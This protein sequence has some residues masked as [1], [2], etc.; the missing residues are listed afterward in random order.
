MNEFPTSGE[1]HEERPA[2]CA[3][4]SA[5]AS[6]ADGCQQPLGDDGREPAG[7]YPV[8]GRTPEYNRRVA[9]HEIGHV[10]L[11]RALSDKPITSVSITRGDGFEGRACGANYKPSSLHLEDQTVSALDSCARIEKLAPGLGSSRTESAELYVRAQ[12][13]VIELV[14]GSIAEKILFPDQPPLRAE[15]D[16]IEARAIAAI[17]CVSPRSVDAM[18]AYAEAEAEHLIRENLNVVL[19]LVDALVESGTL[20]GEQVDVVIA[21]AIAARAAEAER[22]RRADWQRRERSATVFL[23]GLAA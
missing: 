23:E 4:G 17:A 20:D 5:A 15:H 14:A 22:V 8:P 9:G 10:L 6:V 7:A 16:K 21:G 2:L 19:A 3:G 12:T 13:M 18:L 1:G 11:M